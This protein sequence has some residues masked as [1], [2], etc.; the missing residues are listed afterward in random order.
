[1]QI[2]LSSI[3]IFLHTL[4]ALSAASI[5]QLLIILLIIDSFAYD[6]GWTILDDLH[7]SDHFPIYN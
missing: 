6:C 3:P 5:Y 1:M 2:F 7:D 4:M